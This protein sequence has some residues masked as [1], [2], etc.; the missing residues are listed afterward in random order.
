MS[1]TTKEFNVLSPSHIKIKANETCD[2]RLKLKVKKTPLHS[3]SNSLDTTLVSGFA[4]P[5][6]DGTVASI[7]EK[8]D[9]VYLFY[10][11]YGDATLGTQVEAQL[12][13]RVGTQLVSAKSLPIDPNFPNIDVGYASK[14]F[15]KFSVLDDDFVLNMRIRILDPCFNVI[16]SRIIINPNLYYAMGGT[17]SEDGHYLAFAYTVPAAPPSNSLD[18]VILILDATDPSLP[19]VAGPITVSGYDPFLPDVQ[20]FTLV[21]NSGN[22]NLYLTF[23]S[24]QTNFPLPAFNVLPPYFSQVYKVHINSGTISLV[25]QVQLPKYAE[26]TVFVRKSKKEA[27]I[28][29]GGQ[30]TVN[31]TAPNIY[32]VIDSNMI[33]D[34]PPDYNAVRIFRF[35][36]SDEKLDLILK[37]KSNCCSYLRTYPPSDGTFYFLGQSVEIFRTPGDPTTLGPN[38]QEFWSLFKLEKGPKGLV[39]RPQNGPFEDLKTADT[40]FSQDGKWM[41]RVGQ[42]GYLNNDPTLPYVDSVG[43]KNVLLFKVES[44]NYEPVNDLPPKGLIKFQDDS[45]EKER[46]EKDKGN[47]RKHS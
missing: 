47:T 11:N 45:H 5:S 14:D 9:Q 32:T 17:F 10:V 41:L 28:C 43:V 46:K 4:I 18:S 12:F 42:F 24:S 22:K 20:L 13:N 2:G 25:D 16:A 40:V 21:D 23:Q 27:L 36:I 31:P 19:T 33:G 7:S 26:S 37:Q 1:S 3:K 38:P 35:S 6:V 39:L 34:L 44:V 15:T 30:C 8:G 29:H